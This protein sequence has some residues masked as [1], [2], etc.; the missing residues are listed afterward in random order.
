[1]F[2]FFA[3]DDE[4]IFIVT[5][6]LLFRLFQRKMVSGKLFRHFPVFGGGENNSQPENDFRLTKNA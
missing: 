2:Y 5:K 4:V 3:L 1:M 6:T